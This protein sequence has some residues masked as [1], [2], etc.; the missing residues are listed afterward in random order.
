LQPQC[1]CSVLLEVLALFFRPNEF[2]DD[3]HPDYS[4]LVRTDI[5][6]RIVGRIYFGVGN[7]GD[8]WMWALNGWG[9]AQADELEEA[10][11]QLRRQFELLGNKVPWP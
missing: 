6:E 10:K 1:A 7:M 3:R 5:G 2:H 8:T 11:Q 9:S 4:V